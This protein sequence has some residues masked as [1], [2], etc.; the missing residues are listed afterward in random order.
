ML[1]SNC[2]CYQGA[3]IFAAKVN[4]EVQMASEEAIAAIERNGGIVTTGF[5]DPRS[6]GE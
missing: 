4:I 5:Y 3:G 1:A 2:V 6:L